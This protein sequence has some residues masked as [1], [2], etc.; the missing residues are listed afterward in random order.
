MR[1]MNKPVGEPEGGGL[2]GF[3]GVLTT[4]NK[5]E[6]SRRPPHPSRGGHHEG[7]PEASPEAALFLLTPCTGCGPHKYGP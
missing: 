6:F 4:G 1:G 7:G 2:A 5:C 3:E